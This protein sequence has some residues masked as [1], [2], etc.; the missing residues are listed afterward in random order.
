V[1][2]TGQEIGVQPMASLRSID[3]INGTP[4]MRALALRALV[5]SKG[6][7]VWVEEATETRA[8]VKGQ[9][10]G[11]ERVQTSTWTM[12]RAKGLG[13]IGREN[14]RKQPQAMLVARA[15]SELCRLVAADVILGVPYSIEELQDGDEQTQ[16]SV[17]A[18]APVS[19]RTARRRALTVAEAPTE[20]TPEP[21]PTPDPNP[22]AA[23]VVQEGDQLWPEPP[24]DWE[25]TA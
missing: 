24:A 19:R 9:R 10:R 2:L 11:E 4:A 22:V 3:V 18:A 7:R 20:P 14:W 1:I 8:I 21:D 13:L 17:E 16:P 5:Q 25:P 23:E 12:D 15:T 6:H